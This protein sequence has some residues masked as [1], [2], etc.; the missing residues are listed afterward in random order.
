MSS[1]FD[2]HI[3]DSRRVLKGFIAILSGSVVAQL[4]GI[5]AVPVMSRLY[6]P[7]STAHYSLLL[8]IS[9]VLAS[10]ASLRLDLAIPIPNE[11]SESRNLFW[12]AVFTPLFVLSL[13]GLV[14]GL[15]STGGFWGQ[16][17]LTWVDCAAIAVFVMV[18]SVFTAAS[19]LSIRLRSYSLLSQ[20]PVIQMIGT[21]AAQTAFGFLGFSRGLFL[22]GMVGRFFGLTRLARSCDVHFRQAPNLQEAK[23]LM[24]RYWRFPALFAPASSIG[25]LGSNMAVL[26]LPALF[27]FGPA[28]LYAMAY[29]VAGVPMTIINQSAG[30][31][32]LG[33]FARSTTPADSLRV[34][35]RWSSALLLMALVVAT[36]I[37]LL[38]PLLLPWLLGEGW[39]GTAQIAQYTGVMAGAAI[40]GSPIQHVWTVR[41]RALLQF[42]WNLLRVGV[43]AGIIWAGAQAGD[44]MAEVV[45]TLAVATVIVYGLA[46]LGCLF[47]ARS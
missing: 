18:L 36:G 43:T 4:L 30:Q 38:A 39:A 46:W 21:L 27:G 2:S 26:M 33:E 47:A 28:G 35:L 45:S 23:R 14:A 34:F 22:G 20:I 13:S 9:S 29:K 10:F 1:E 5:A 31:V 8:G 44:S 7:E 12:V 3:N 15:M 17:G 19:Q 25:V 24:K 37:W 41:Q 16:T 11:V 40:F 32:F 6:S 42:V